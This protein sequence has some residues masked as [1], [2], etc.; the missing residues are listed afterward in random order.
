M[1]ASLQAIERFNPGTAGVSTF[2]A[3]RVRGAIVDHIRGL[4]HTPRLV[5]SNAKKLV[6]AR[7]SVWERLGAGATDEAVAA[8]MGM[9]GAEFSTYTEQNKLRESLSID[10]PNPL[11]EEADNDAA[12]LKCRRSTN[13]AKWSDQLDVLRMVCRGLSKR[14]R[15][16]V[17]G[18]YFENDTLAEIARQLALSEARVSQMHS[19]IIERLRGRIGTLGEYFAGGAR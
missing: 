11:D 2:L 5:R 17:I 3:M 8:E 6:T 19:Q 14:E 12:Q 10:R 13:P 18:Y 16:I 15:L 7:R 9:S 1:A 4:D